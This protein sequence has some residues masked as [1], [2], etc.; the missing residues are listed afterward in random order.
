MSIEKHSFVRPYLFS[1]WGCGVTGGTV[2]TTGQKKVKGSRLEVGGNHRVI[3]V[4][5]K[6]SA[7]VL[8]FKSALSI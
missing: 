6:D 5:S 4:E 3:S 2:V 1:I 7:A 8:W